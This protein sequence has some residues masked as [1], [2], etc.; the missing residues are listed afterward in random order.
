MKKQPSFGWVTEDNMALL[1]DLYELTM[2]ASYLKSRRNEL[3]TFELFVRHLPP[4]RSFLV[5]AG[6]EQIILF[7]ET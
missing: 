3:S 7:L 4:N 5:S 2:A 1:T 6:V